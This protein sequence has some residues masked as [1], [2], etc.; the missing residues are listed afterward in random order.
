MAAASGVLPGRAATA[1]AAWWVV[2]LVGTLEVHAIKSRVKPRGS[3]DWTRWASPLAS[4]ATLLAG[5]VIL[6]AGP[7]SFRS[8]ALAVLPPAGALLVLSFLRVHPRHLKRV[9]WTLVGSQLLT[10]LALVSA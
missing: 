3:R 8:A 9:G 6:S 4:A 2:F 7:A 1:A 10:L 5:A